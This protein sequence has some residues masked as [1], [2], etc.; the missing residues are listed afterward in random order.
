MRNDDMTALEPGRVTPSQA[1]PGASPGASWPA[2]TWTWPAVSAF[3]LLLMAMLIGSRYHGNGVNMPVLLYAMLP[4]LGAML[5]VLSESL[6]IGHSWRE[7]PVLI[8]A[9]G[10]YL[11]L[12]TINVQISQVEEISFLHWWMRASLPFAAFIALHLIT[13]QRHGRDAVTWLIIGVCLIGAVWGFS[14]F[15]RIRQRI[16]GPFIDPNNLAI[17]SAFGFLLLVPRIFAQGS[18][19]MRARDMRVAVLKRIALWIALAMFTF[20]VFATFSR[21]VIVIWATALLFLLGLR[22]WRRE[23][24]RELL[25]LLA[26]GA[27]SYGITASLAPAASSRYT[28]EGDFALGLDVRYAMW[29]STL[30]MWLEHPWLGSGMGAFRT[31]Y[32]NHR[33]LVDQFTG[34]NIPHNDYLQL[35]YEG[36]PL[37]L[38]FMLLIVMAVVVAGL[39][40]VRA[41]MHREPLRRKTNVDW[42]RLGVALAIGGVMAHATINFVAILEIWH[43][44]LG[45]ALALLFGRFCERA[46]VPVFTNPRAPRLVVALCAAAMLF[47]LRSL[48]VDAA[49]YG[50]I[51]HQDGVPFANDIRN[52]GHQYLKA[53]SMLETLAPDRGLPPYGEAYYL[54]LLATELPPAAAKQFAEGAA[55]AYQRSLDNFPYT[56]RVMVSYSDLYK[57]PSIKDLP[58]AERIARRAMERDPTDLSAAIALNNVLVQ[59]KREREAYELLRDR[60]FPWA[61]LNNVRYPEDSESALKQLRIWSMKFGAGPAIADV[62]RVLA[63]ATKAANVVR[64]Q[65]A[66]SRAWRAAKAKVAAAATSPTASSALAPQQH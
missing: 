33:E 12:C 52:D 25:V 22:L 60:M 65:H 45:C 39:P 66:K 32:P 10:L 40:L 28:R 27:V 43:L 30:R 58:H 48:V 44:F 21:A 49:S 55:K 23:S 2:R 64:E 51:L 35:L 11:L 15:V 16:H 5:C 13:S 4:L 26:I 62:D 42:S 41:A 61:V 7:H 29:R 34:G 19:E 17:A 24:A 31:F 47:P 8:G 59:E 18:N 6:R 9:L 57:L 50:I 3:L 56:L 20:V 53:M 37:M 14:D 38:G 36:G 54:N 1:L 46:A 63:G